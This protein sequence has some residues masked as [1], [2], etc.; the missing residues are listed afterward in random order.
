[1]PPV[2]PGEIVR[3][4]NSLAPPDSSSGPASPTTIVGKASTVAWITLASPLNVV[5][6]EDVSEADG[7]YV[8]GPVGFSQPTSTDA[9]SASNAMRFMMPSFLTQCFMVAL[10]RE[11]PRCR[12]PSGKGGRLSV[13]QTCSSVCGNFLQAA[14]G[15]TPTPRRALLDL[16]EAGVEREADQL[17]AVL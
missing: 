10:S 1:M 2:S 9:A 14:V 13:G 17:G 6:V 4:E 15:G 12:Q 5:R 3:S 11:V 7:S 16:E 8:V